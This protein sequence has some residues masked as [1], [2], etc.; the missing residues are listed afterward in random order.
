M[1]KVTGITTSTVNINN[2]VTVYG[3]DVYIN[4]KVFDGWV[5]LSATGTRHAIAS[6]DCDE[7]YSVVTINNVNIALAEARITSYNVCYTKLLRFKLLGIVGSVGGAGA[8]GVGISA[9]VVIAHNTIEAK[10][11]AY[12]TITTTSGDVNSYNFV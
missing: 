8:V 10:A 5:S 3:A 6:K 1:A 2:L 11:G 4:A 12:S 7:I 9:M